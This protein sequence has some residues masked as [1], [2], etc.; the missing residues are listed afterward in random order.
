MTPNDSM[1]LRRSFNS[2]PE[3]YD[4]VRPGYP[5]EVFDDLAALAELEAGSRV[6]EIGCGTGQATVALT[7][8]GYRVIAVELGSE[9]AA[10]ARRRLAAYPDVEVIV[11]SFEDW[12]L[13]AQ[14]FD[15]VVSATAF[16][17]IDPAVRVHKAAQSLR[18]GGSLAIIETRRIPV[19]SE[20]FLA[21][22]W[23]CHERWD[24]TTKP[25]RKPATG[26]PPESWIEVDRS[27]LFDRVISRR[28]ESEQEYM[29]NQFLDL[30]MTFSSVLVLDPTQQAGLL[31]CLGELI[32]DEGRGRIGESIVNQL[33]VAR[34]ASLGP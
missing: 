22:L 1:K 25:A 28:Y 34:R 12:S 13:P 19:G 18:P 21:N 5:S 16:H 29:T 24:P 8:R 11:S 31:R 33:L 30:L 4:R 15:A 7:E 10:F 27:G 17:W 3:R 14:G 26:E 2:A 6:L 23:R 20:Q 32:D 9:L